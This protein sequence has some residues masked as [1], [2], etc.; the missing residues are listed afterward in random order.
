MDYYIARQPIFSYNKSLYAYE[1]LYRHDTQNA[2][3]DG[4][5]GDMATRKVISNAL[6]TF[7]LDSLTNG[8]IAFVN[9]TRHLLL[10]EVP[11]LLSPDK[12]AIEILEDIPLDRP[13]LYTLQKYKYAGFTI[14]LDDYT[15]T[16]IPHE[17]LSLLDIIKVDFK[18]T[19]RKAQREIVDRIKPWK[20]K[21]LAE[22][23]ETKEDYEAACSFGYS[24][25]QGYYFSKP[26]VLEKSAFSISSFSYIKLME[27]VSKP[28]LDFKNIADTIY[29]DAELTLL[30]MKKMRSIQYYRRHAVSSI[31]LALVRMGINEVRR[32][33]TLLLLQDILG[34]EMDELLRSGLIRAVFCE[35]LSGAL[36]SEMQRASFCAGL[37]S[38][39]EAKDESFYQS[40]E[41]LG[42]GGT[43]IDA[44]K[45]GNELG[46]CLDLIRAYEIG[47]WQLVIFLLRQYFTHLDSHD[48]NTMYMASVNYADSALSL[49]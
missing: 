22:K 9:F 44:L 46:R 26:V 1:L 47:D 14:A 15:G 39:I 8:R 21:L 34:P 25:F 10:S 23:I 33:V 2:F 49:A 36:S 35:C 4:I 32:W 42:I 30:L 28:D 27:E 40:L 17:F 18:D 16:H 12:F 31:T 41:H 20:G 3:S 29:L 5:D 11:E 43:L 24:L 38:I 45:G 13:L 37:F 48:L 6:F 7:D 19:D